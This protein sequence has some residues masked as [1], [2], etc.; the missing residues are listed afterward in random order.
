MERSAIIVCADDGMGREIGLQRL[1]G[2]RKACNTDLD[3]L[4][5]AEK[6][7]SA[8]LMR[9]RQCLRSHRCLVIS[10]RRTITIWFSMAHS[11]SARACSCALQ[12]WSTSALVW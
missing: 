1:L 12:A 2:R 8:L 5:D 4:A 6:S 3:N 11:K 9:L 7:C 10:R